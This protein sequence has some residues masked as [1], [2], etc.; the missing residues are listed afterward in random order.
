VERLLT[1]ESFRTPCEVGTI[2]L[3]DFLSRNV[4]SRFK[5]SSLICVFFFL[6]IRKRSRTYLTSFFFSAHSSSVMPNSPSFLSKTLRFLAR[7]PAAILA[8]SV[9]LRFFPLFQG[10]LPL[11][12]CAIFERDE[13]VWA[14]P[15][16]TVLRAWEG[17]KST[18]SSN[19]KSSSL[20]FRFFFSG[21]LPSLDDSSPLPLLFFFWVLLRLGLMGHVRRFLISVFEAASVGP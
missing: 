3:V 17:R 20:R 16:F 6:C 21:A 12:A 19:S 7:T 11:L 1:C 13:L 18:S 9:E 5:Y 14:Y 2:G 15:P 4:C 10:L 8:L